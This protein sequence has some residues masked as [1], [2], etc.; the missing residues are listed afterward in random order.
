MKCPRCGSEMELDQHR[1]AQM[2]MCY[3]CGYI[4]DQYASVNTPKETNF[5]HLMKLRNINEASAFIANGLNLA[6]SA[7]KDWMD[8]FFN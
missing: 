5:Q 7:V 6:P 1:R 8:K 2:Y 3:V 4:E